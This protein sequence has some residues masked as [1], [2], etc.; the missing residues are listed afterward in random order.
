MK[1]QVVILGSG[2]AG[3]VTALHLLRAGIT[4]T[5]IEREKFPRYHIGESL[6]T[7]CGE[8]CLLYTSPSPRDRG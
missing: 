3:T 1:R 2:P 8:I 6:T 5:I 4:P 7:D